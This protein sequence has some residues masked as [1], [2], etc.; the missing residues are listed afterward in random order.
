MGETIPEA[1]P[2]SMTMTVAGLERNLGAIIA[3][4]G[5][6]CQKL[7]LLDKLKAEVD[8]YYDTLAETLAELEFKVGVGGYFKGEGD[9]VY[10]LVVPEGHFVKYKPLAYL[11][12][13]QDGERA[14]SLSRKEADEWLRSQTAP[15]LVSPILLPVS[16]ETE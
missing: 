9:T 12:T 13:K 1:E 3:S 14:G 7:I 5:D 4:T 11:R 15:A 10:K 16:G 6:P 8:A 2:L